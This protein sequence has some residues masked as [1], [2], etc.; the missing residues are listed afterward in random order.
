MV[1][2]CELRTADTKLADCA[3]RAE[4]VCLWV[5]Y[6]EIY[7]LADGLTDIDA[8]FAVVRED[9]ADEGINASFCWAV[10]VYDSPCSCLLGVR[11]R[12]GSDSPRINISL[13]QC[14][15]SKHN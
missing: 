11:V 15:T 9:F 14:F 2:R 1:F 3:D 10:G 8:A 12:R 13:S 5:G 7:T 6:P 4:N